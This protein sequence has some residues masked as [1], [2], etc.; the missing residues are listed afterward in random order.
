MCCI[1]VDHDEF[2][3]N[4]S[5]TTSASVTTQTPPEWGGSW[6]QGLRFARERERSAFRM[7]GTRA[8]CVIVIIVACIMLCSI[9]GRAQN[10]QPSSG[11]LSTSQRA[12]AVGNDLQMAQRYYA[13]MPKASADR[14]E[15]RR[16]A[17]ANGA[18]D[19]ATQIMHGRSVPAVIPFKQKVYMKLMTFCNWDTYGHAS[20]GFAGP[21]G[22]FKDD[23][24]GEPSRPLISPESRDHFT[25]QMGVE[26]D[27]I[28]GAPQDGGNAGR[29]NSKHFIGEHKIFA[30]QGDA[31]MLYI[32]IYEREGIS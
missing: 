16:T 23:P 15:R 32:Y 17:L 7:V 22:R 4:Y 5:D 21:Y 6:V 14:T 10:S 24:E 3:T 11:L 18:Q 30:D 8:L 20:T 9:S 31:D 1:D 27:I 25:S 29:G 12:I 19:G 13:E 26:R 28:W 2:A